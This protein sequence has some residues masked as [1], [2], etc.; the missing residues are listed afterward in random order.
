ML[1]TRLASVALVNSAGD[2]LADSLE[3]INSADG[4]N[5]FTYVISQGF[6]KEI[7]T[8]SYV[9]AKGLNLNAGIAVKSDTQAGDLMIGAFFEYGKADY[10]SYLDDGTHGQGDSDYIGGGVFA[11]F[12]TN[13]GFYGEASFRAGRTSYDYTGGVLDTKDFNFDLK[14]NYY[15][16]HFGLG[17]EFY[18]DKNKMDIYAK[19]FH[20]YTKG[21]EFSQGGVDVKFDSVKSQRL[22]VG[23]KDTMAFDPNNKLYIGA[24]YEYEFSG[25]A[26]GIISHAEFGSDSIV[27]PKL[28]G[29]SGIGE[30]GYIY[31]NGNF[32]FIIGAKGYIGRQRGVSGNLGFNLKF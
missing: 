30:I 25:D 1:E 6:D 7:E 22:R 4:E 16:V 11:K 2:L 17:Q 29:S 23:I 5:I 20:G 15:G 26:N 32:E 31:E 24:A 14:S 3:K 8:G 27:S 13:S 19:Y 21:N 10:D 9:D 28:K 18:F 12:I